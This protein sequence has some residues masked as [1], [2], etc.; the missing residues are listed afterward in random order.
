MTKKK[1]YQERN[2]FLANGKIDTV[3]DE[4]ATFWPGLHKKSCFTGHQTH[5]DEIGGKKTGNQHC[6]LYIEKGRRGSLLLFE[7]AE[8]AGF[9][10]FSWF[11][12]EINI[13][14]TWNWCKNY[15]HIYIRR[16]PIA[17]HTWLYISL[18]GCNE[19]PCGYTLRRHL[20]YFA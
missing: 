8:C 16:A 18:R 10:P 7:V 5:S 1:K 13:W 3:W 19:I 2:N 15:T 12:Y 4:K 14:Q 11:W 6:L 9:L 20:G 17:M